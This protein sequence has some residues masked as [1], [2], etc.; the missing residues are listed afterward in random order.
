MESRVEFDGE[1]L[2]TPGLIHDELSGSDE[3]SEN[4][5]EAS[6]DAE[7]Q[8]LLDGALGQFKESADPARIVFD[9]VMGLHAIRNSLSYAGWQRLIPV[10][11]AHEVAAYFL[12]DP[13]TRWSAVKPRGY[14]GDAG[15]LDFI[16]GHESVK[17]HIEGAS[18]L[19]RALYGYTRM[20]A[21]S[22][23]VRERRDILARMV[24][25]I[26]ASKPGECEILTIAAGHLREGSLSELVKNDGLKR[27]VALDQDPSSVAT[28][29]EEHRG[30]KI[31]A[32]EGSVRTVLARGERLGRFD[33]IYA[34]GLYDYL[35]HKVAVKLTRKALEML[36]PGGKFLFANFS[37]DFPD[38]GYMESFMHWALLLRTEEDMWAV[39][40]EAGEGFSYD[41]EVFY[42]NNRAI[43][44]ATMTLR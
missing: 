25:E 19:G 8:A 15:L 30:T 39:I 34:A 36:K 21:S 11:R 38:D 1:S 10:A 3:N 4:N 18:D 6:A 14:S 23:A 26:G 7:L 24:D 33:F 22:V 27:W 35:A 44:Y 29:A 13:F 17:E 2:I 5:V 43:V 37:D 42:G 40:R 20:A 16:Y 9:T 32:T 28:V 31:E 12:Q 41:A